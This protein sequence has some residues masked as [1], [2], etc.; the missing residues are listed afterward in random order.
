MLRNHR[1]FNTG[2]PYNVPAGQGGANLDALI[3][4]YKKKNAEHDAAKLKEMREGKKE[5]DPNE[6]VRRG[7]Y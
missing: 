2:S 7:T 6:V 3:A 1:I 4:H 5:P